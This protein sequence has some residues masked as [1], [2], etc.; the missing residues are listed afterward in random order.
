MERERG[1]EGRLVRG[2]RGSRCGGFLSFMGPLGYVSPMAEFRVGIS[3]EPTADQMADL[4]FVGI[5]PDDK[6]G[7][8]NDAG[9][10]NRLDSKVTHVLLE[11]EDETEARQKVAEAL[12]ITPR[13]IVSAHSRT[14]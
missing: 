7:P 10:N 2:F 5:E 9:Y 8:T 13:D 12:G 4:R 1:K 14:S 6:F 11:A 3:G